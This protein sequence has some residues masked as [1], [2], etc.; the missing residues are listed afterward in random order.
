[1]KL[2]P[3][4]SKSVSYLLTIPGH[5]FLNPIP[6]SEIPEPKPKIPESEIPDRY[7]R[8]DFEK[9]KFISS[10]SGIQPRYPN[11]PNYPKSI[12]SPDQA[13]TT[14]PSSP[15]LIL[16]IPIIFLT[17]THPHPHIRQM[18]PD[19]PSPSGPSHIPS[20]AGCRLPGGAT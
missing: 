10:N 8:Y 9:P 18:P 19:S 20:P 3:F 15:H 16:A 12:R 11:N 14:Q 2:V 1:M 7:F 13:K 6:E 5:N 4:F 17:L